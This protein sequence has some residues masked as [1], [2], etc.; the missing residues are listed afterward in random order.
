M[1]KIMLAQSIK[2]YSYIPARL[3][4][5]VCNAGYE[6]L[7]PMFPSYLKFSPPSFIIPFKKYNLFSHLSLI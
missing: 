1:L 6:M 3:D 2:A 4:Y 5:Y 7:Y